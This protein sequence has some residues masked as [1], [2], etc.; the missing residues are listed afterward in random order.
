[1]KKYWLVL[2]SYTF[3]WKDDKHVVFYSSLIGKGIDVYITESIYPIVKQL[4]D[5]D[6]LYC[7]EIT[8]K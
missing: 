8:N 2:D 7:V 1:M 5:V 3:L 6:N 4:L